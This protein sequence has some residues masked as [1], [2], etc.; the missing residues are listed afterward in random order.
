VAGRVL[1]GGAILLQLEADIDDRGVVDE[2]KLL[3][4]QPSDLYTEQDLE[5]CDGGSLIREGLV[6]CDRLTPRS[7]VQ[8][9]VISDEQRRNDGG[10]ELPRPV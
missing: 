4:A 5:S 8:A 7:L 2:V 6:Q 10:P 9:R 1:G 3:D